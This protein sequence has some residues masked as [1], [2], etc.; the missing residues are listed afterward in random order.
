MSDTPFE[1]PE[2]L[3]EFRGVV[4]QIAEERIGLA[5]AA[6][7]DDEDEF[8]WDVH[9]VFVENDL[10]AVGYPEEFGG[11][12][13]G[14][15]TVAVMIEEISRI[16]AGCAL[17]PLVSRLGAIPII[18]AGSEDQRR[19]LFGAIARGEHQMSYCLTEPGSGSDAVCDEDAVRARRRRVPPVRDEAVHHRRR[20]LR[21]VHG[22]RHPR[23]GRAREGHL[24]VPGLQRRPGRVVRGQEH[25]LGIHGSP[26]ARCTSTT[27][28]VAAD[29]LIG[30]R[31]R[32]VLDRDADARLLA[33]DHRRP[34]ARD[35][36]GCLRRRGAVRDER[37]QFGK[38]IAEFQGIQF[39]L[40]DMAMEIE[41]AR[42][43]VYR[44]AAMVDAGNP[45]MTLLAA[46]AKAYASDVAMKVTTDAVQVLG[47]YGYMRE[48]P[49]RADDARREDHPDLRGHQPDPAGRHRP[50]DPE[51][52][53]RDRVTDAPARTDA[54]RPPSAS[55]VVLVQLM[56][57]ADA[58]LLGNVHGGSVMRL[59]DTA[60]GLAAIK[61]SGG[62]VVTVAMDEMS[63]MEPVRVGDVV[64]VKARVNDV[65]TTSMEV[66]V[67]VEAENPVTGA[68]VHSSSA[69]LV[70]VA[71]DGKG[72][73][74]PV[75]LL[76][77]QTPDERRR[78]AEAKL[79]R[80]ARLARKRAIQAARAAKGE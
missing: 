73:P 62:A 51:G 79:R 2:E 74:R 63:F 72:S 48:Y 46:M 69:Y 47:G 25:K 36:A 50:A 38:P 7:I 6:E 44:A 3:E 15:L 4:R 12:G 39:M 59:V 34:G 23:P 5:R 21:R 52:H 19:D 35:R 28:E 65:G 33:A 14:S 76:E 67:R 56:E 37:E 32:G 45:R 80:Q 41:A 30:E 26:T 10:M 13:G 70:Y 20:R 17:I 55:E 71:L 8:P 16:S 54:P 31:G 66:G 61:H 29:R 18:L 42:R 40:A 9:K 78:Q 68:C 24:R 60:G 64:T 58:N 77:P 1:L 22:V 27:C 11:A 43:L 49:G 75:P 53:R 57:L